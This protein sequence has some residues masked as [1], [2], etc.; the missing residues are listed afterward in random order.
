MACAWTHVR[1]ERERPRRPKDQHAHG[2]QQRGEHAREEHHTHTDALGDARV[3]TQSLFSLPLSISQIA[4]R[5][6]PR[7]ESSLRAHRVCARVDAVARLA[8]A[9][10]HVTRDEEGAGETGAGAHR[11]GEHPLAEAHDDRRHDEHGREGATSRSLHNDTRNRPA[12]LNLLAHNLKP[13]LVGLSFAYVQVR[14]V[15]GCW[16]VRVV[17]FIAWCAPR[18]FQYIFMPMPPAEYPI[19]DS[20]VLAA[21]I[22]KRNASL[23]G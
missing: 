17:S 20:Q 6:P 10:P 4:H 9:L 13:C 12:V 19:C 5:L 15:C 2:E 1:A 3:R 16:S 23:T 22:L 11:H 21:A 8:R 14:G 7:A 18:C